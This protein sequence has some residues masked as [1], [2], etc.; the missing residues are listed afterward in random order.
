MRS[1]SGLFSTTGLRRTHLALACFFLTLASSSETTLCE[2]GRGRP[3]GC[4]RE[5]AECLHQRQELDL[6]LVHNKWR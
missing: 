5:L 2:T 3:Q 6:Q 4:F 1:P